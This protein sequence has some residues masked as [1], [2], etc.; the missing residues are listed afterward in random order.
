MVATIMTHCIVG[1]NGNCNVLL[2]V[3]Q[4]QFG[5]I[6]ISHQNITLALTALAHCLGVVVEDTQYGGGK[7]TNIQ[8]RA[9]LLQ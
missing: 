1:Y 7:G 9:Y 6:T 3:G 8:P 4:A 2:V 5:H